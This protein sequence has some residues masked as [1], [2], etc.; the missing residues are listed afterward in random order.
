VLHAIRAGR[1]VA[2]IDFENGPRATRRL[3]VDLGATND[4]LGGI[5]Y[6]EPD[7]PPTAADVES[8]VGAAV[9]LV[10]ID[11]S[12]GAFH[13]SGLDDNKR[14]DVEAF[15][16]Q[17]V[18][19]L[20]QAGVGTVVLDH[21]TKAA[22]GRGKYAIGSEREVGQVDV[23]LGLEAVGTPLTRGGSGLVKVRVHK[24]RPGFL[25]RQRGL[26][27]TPRSTANESGSSRLYVP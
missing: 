7:G 14:Q 6:V 11:A 19:P 20:C 1:Q 21:V 4:E 3:L 10:V 17:W 26:R 9:E 27:F 22:E 8:I 12:M 13:A 18:T 15:A 16:A 25:Q 24:D 5:Y 2:I 23:H